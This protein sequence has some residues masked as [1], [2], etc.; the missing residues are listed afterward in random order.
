MLKQAETGRKEVRVVADQ[1]GRPTAT[2][3]LAE[4]LLALVDE[5]ASGI[6]HYA[7]AGEVSWND[8][9]REIYRQAG[10]GSVDVLPISSDDLAR[11]AV[12]PAYSVLST[13]K[14]EALTGRVPRDFREPLSEYLARRIPA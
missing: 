4:A 8:F 6:V 12:R 13:K 7:N 11:P 9:A 2:T 10:F 1:T 3:D 5:G 14:Y